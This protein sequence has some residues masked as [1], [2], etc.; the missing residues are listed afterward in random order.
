M[1]SPICLAILSM[2][3]FFFTYSQFRPRAGNPIPRPA[4]VREL[5][6]LANRKWSVALFEDDSCE[7][8]LGVQRQFLSKLQL[9]RFAAEQQVMLH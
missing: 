8:S 7:S 6:E 4:A 5:T 3:L 9:L 2:L 1:S